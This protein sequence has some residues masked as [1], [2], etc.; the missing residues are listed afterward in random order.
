MASSWRWPLSNLLA[1]IVTVVVNGLANAL[2]LN[3]ITTGDVINRD[4]TLF[5]PANWVFA[6][7]GLIYL[8]LAIFVVYGLLPMGR[9]NPR[10]RRISPWFVLSCAANTV[11]LFLWHYDLLPISMVAMIVLL[12]SLIAIY[13]LLHRGV[14]RG[15]VEPGRFEQIALRWPFSLYLG[16]TCVATIA[17]ATVVLDRAGWTGWGL[18]PVLWTA[19]MLVVGGVLG[20]ALGLGMADPI[21]PAVF[22]WAFVGIAMRQREVPLVTAVAAIVAVALM[23][24]ALLA[25]WRRIRTPFGPGGRFSRTSV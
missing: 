1:L 4:P 3:G 20:A 11:W 25:L 2:P 6:I 23:V 12:G 17:N 21:I 5:L 14:G 7:W 10:L 24:I 19:I 22:V 8:A 9:H 18:D 13:R 16:W 15:E